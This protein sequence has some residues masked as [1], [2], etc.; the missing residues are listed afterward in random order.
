[1]AHDVD[2]THNAERHRYELRVDGELASI[3]EYTPAG[4]RFVFDHTETAAA[5]RGRGLA[6]KLV[7]AA[8]EDVR[9]RNGGVV[10]SCSFVAEF[11]DEHPEF[12]DLLGK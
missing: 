4:A 10:P 6:E 2:I 3:A 5:F 8:L 9:K 12:A 1:M 11:M 7:R